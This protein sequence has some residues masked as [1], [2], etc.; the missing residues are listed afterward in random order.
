MGIVFATLS[1]A[2][3]PAL[4]RP[5][6]RFVQD[7][8]PLAPVRYRG[9]ESCGHVRAYEAQIV[10]LR[11]GAAWGAITIWSALMIVFSVQA[12]S[13]HDYEY[14]L[15]QW[16]LVLSGANPW[17]TD[18]AY[19]PLHN[20]LAYALPLGPLAPK[21]IM[22]GALIAANALLF[23]ELVR[24]SKGADDYVVYLL[25]V[26]TNILV[27]SVGFAYGL[28]D[29]LV[30]AFVICAT[31]ARFHGRTVLAGCLL[32]LATLLK[33]YALFL[34]P[35][36]ALHENGFR[37]RLIAG[38]TV[39]ILIG[40]AAAML[41][42][43]NNFLAA[44]SFG[45]MRE[46]TI[47]SIL[48]PLHSHPYLIGGPYVRN[49]LIQTNA[50]FVVAVYLVF[51]YAACRL[52][53]NWLEASVVGFMLVLLTYKVGNQQFY[54]SWLFLVAALPLAGTETSRRLAWLCVPFALFLSLF[55]WGYAYKTD[56]Y[57][58]VLVEVRTYCGFVAFALGMATV[59]SYFWIRGAS[60]RNLAPAE[61][62]QPPTI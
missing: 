53:L 48:S 21:L 39:V 46:P 34:L 17:A 51:L 60:G 5:S 32:G 49:F 16:K 7:G 13:Q 11:L 18:N 47:L 19:G 15:A 31:I 22:V 24:A 38:G 41:A 45:I 4:T 27:I 8:G 57:K 42:W 40:A 26:P 3:G 14:Y 62:R 50:A 20:L 29:T 10:A 52:R 36:F 1:Y 9:M 55:Q 58:T 61:K 44:L 25:A 56:Y 12:R 6:A 35:L 59:L 28:N 37:W 2:R 54:I 30:A 43:G 23:F 33:F